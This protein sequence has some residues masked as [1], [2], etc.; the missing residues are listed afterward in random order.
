MGIE[1]TTQCFADIAHPR[2]ILALNGGS[3]GNRTL[4]AFQLAQ[5]SKLV[6]YLTCGLPLRPMFEAFRVPMT[7]AVVGGR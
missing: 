7:T 5:L 4:S 1:P 2:R 6:T 3:R